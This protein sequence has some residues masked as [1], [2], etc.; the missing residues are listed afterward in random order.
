[1]VG[2]G[3]HFGGRRGGGL[4]G[5]R[6]SARRRGGPA[7]GSSS[8]L[9]W[10]SAWAV[11]RHRGLLGRD[12]GGRLGLGWTV[13]G[14]VGRCGGRTGGA[15][16]G[17]DDH[18]GRSAGRAGAAG[19]CSATSTAPPATATEAEHDRQRLGRAGD[20][21]RAG[22]GARR[23][24]AG[25]AECPGEPAAEQQ[26]GRAGE[27]AREL[28]V[29]V[30]QRLA[31]GAAALAHAQVVAQE[32]RR[33][34]GAVDRERELLADAGAVGV[35]RLG[36]LGEPAAGAHEQRLHGGDGD[37]ERGAELLVGEAL[38]LA[39]DERRALLLREVVEVGDE[40]PEVLPALG[41][42]HR[43]GAA[44][45]QL[46]GL[47]RRRGGAADVVDAAVVGDAVEPRAHGD[48]AVAGAQ[49]AVGAEEDVLHDVLRL[50]G[51]A[52][53]VAHVGEQPRFVAV[54]DTRNASSRPARK[55]ASNCSSERRRSSGVGS[56][57]GR[58]TAVAT[59]L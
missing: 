44:G 32:A 48:L 19:R 29:A 51:A 50:G 55:R 4:G 27:Q 11:W 57:R 34:A 43:V 56:A 42:D 17:G 38:E 28:G 30:A 33:A 20:Q 15:V 14:G 54:V 45:E 21:R 41:L 40:A 26:P 39:D 3:R 9:R 59:A 5:C 52:Q 31:V 2:A 16:G 8:A 47:Q 36:G 53:H 6:R 23:P 25:G 49:G 58:G 22:D 35:A 46:V 13:G 10:G 7:S 37:A 24:A 12:D 1:M 18:G